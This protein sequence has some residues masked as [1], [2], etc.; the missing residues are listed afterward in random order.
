VGVEIKFDR[1]QGGTE[2]VTKKEKPEAREVGNK[3]FFRLTLIIHGGT[4]G[5]REERSCSKK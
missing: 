4:G 2:L 3:N 5:K 1:K